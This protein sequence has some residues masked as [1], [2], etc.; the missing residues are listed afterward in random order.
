MKMIPGKKERCINVLKWPIR[1]NIRL[2]LIILSRLY[3]KQTKISVTKN[4][5]Y[6][7]MY[8]SQVR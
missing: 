8:D 2:Y 4:S 7:V 1:P 5:V 6:L 3:E